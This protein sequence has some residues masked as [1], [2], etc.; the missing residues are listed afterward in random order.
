MNKVYRNKVSMGA[1]RK[2]DSPFVLR[3]LQKI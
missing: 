1:V 2:I 3:I